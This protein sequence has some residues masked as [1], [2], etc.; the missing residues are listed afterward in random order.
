MLT[1]PRVFLALFVF[2]AA[3]AHAD[4]PKGDPKALKGAADRALVKE[5]FCEATYLFVRLDEMAPSVDSALGLGDAASQANDRARA[6]QGF[7]AYLARSAP[8]HPRRSS[9]QKQLDA[10]KELMAQKGPGT[11]CSDPP[12]ECGNGAFEPGEE[13]DDGNRSDG[14]ACSAAC[15]IPGAAPAALSPPFPAAPGAAPPAGP[16]TTESPPVTGADA[17][18]SSPPTP[19]PSPDGSPTP[20]SIP[21]SIPPT[22]PAPEGSPST[23]PPPPPEQEPPAGKSPL[24]GILVASAGGVVAV[25]GIAGAVWGLLPFINYYTGVPRLEELAT[26]YDGA[27]TARERRLVAGGTADLRAQ[28]AN[29]ANTWNNVA[30]WVTVGA[31]VAAAAGIGIAVLGGLMIGGSDEKEQE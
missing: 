11:S 24:P 8:N 26:R 27:D 29:E 4:A 25:G 17:P 21:P 5:R 18:P 19:P 31:S 23:E 6:V 2:V 30:R 3:A 1:T 13:C 16:T 20:P 9:V 12:A 14:D 22:A 10:I 28:L 15:R 7:D